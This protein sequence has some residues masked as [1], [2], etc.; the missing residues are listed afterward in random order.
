MKDSPFE[1]FLPPH[2]YWSNLDPTSSPQRCIIPS[3]TSLLSHREN[4][5]KQ[6]WRIKKKKYPAAHTKKCFKCFRKYTSRFLSF[7]VSG[8]NFLVFKI[9]F[10]WDTPTALTVPLRPLCTKSSRLIS[11]AFPSAEILTV[12]FLF[13][14]D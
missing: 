7:Y 13:P 10:P 11:A 9:T 2:K 14:A 8:W 3:C 6:F 5:G 12:S 4:Q 1:S